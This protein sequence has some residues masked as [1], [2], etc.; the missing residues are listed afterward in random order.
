MIGP[1]AWWRRSIH[2]EAGSESG[3][4][5]HSLSFSELRTRRDRTKAV[6]DLWPIVPASICVGLLWAIDWRV[7]LVAGMISIGI[8]RV[9]QS[10]RSDRDELAHMENAIQE[11]AHVCVLARRENPRGASAHAVRELMYRSEGAGA[12][13][14]GVAYRLVERLLADETQQGRA[15]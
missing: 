15:P 3:Y 5:W 10:V 2:T 1:R 7:A 13:W 9:A 6:A 4:Q 14:P 8:G 11:M 12:D